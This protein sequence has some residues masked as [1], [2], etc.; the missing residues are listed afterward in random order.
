MANV[1]SCS[2]LLSSA[3]SAPPLRETFTLEN[4]HPCLKTSSYA[5][6]TKAPDV[7]LCP[8]TDGDIPQDELFRLSEGDQES[9]SKLGERDQPS[10]AMDTSRMKNADAASSGGSRKRSKGTS[11]ASPSTVSSTANKLRDLILRRDQGCVLSG[12]W[13][14]RRLEAANVLTP[15]YIGYWAHVEGRQRYRLFS[16]HPNGNRHGYKYDARVA[17][18]KRSDLHRSY[19]A[20]D[21][22]NIVARR[23]YFDADEDVS[24]DLAVFDAEAHETILKLAIERMGL[25]GIEGE[26]LEE[27]WFFK[28]L[29]VGGSV[30]AP[31]PASNS[32][33][34][35]VRRRE[36]VMRSGQMPHRHQRDR[37]LHQFKSVRGLMLACIEDLA[38]GKDQWKS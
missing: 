20:F 23:C 12:E 9:M 27:M 16:E 29:G 1:V 34:F 14:S 18:T 37:S 7:T 19:D 6:S 24:N 32:L 11:A 35:G 38:L 25:S 26:M 36:R 4:L 30:L 2:P 21:F 22:F 33:L 10:Y 15:E 31:P 8:I 28:F 5:L 17:L 13:Q 3:R